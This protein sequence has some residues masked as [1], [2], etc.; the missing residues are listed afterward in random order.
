MDDRYER[1][2]TVRAVGTLDVL[3][4]GRREEA[5]TRAVRN[6]VR[7]AELTSALQV[8][9]PFGAPFQLPM[10]LDELIAGRSLLGS[11]PGTPLVAVGTLEWQQRDDPRYASR[12]RERG[13][14]VTEVVFRPHHIEPA[15]DT[16]EPGCDVWLEGRVRRE[17]RRYLHPER[18][19]PIAVVGLEIVVERMRRGSLAR[20]LEAVE[21]QVAIPVAHPDLPKLLRR[22]NLV[23]VDGMLE[24]VV[25]PLRTDDEQVRR[26]VAELDQRWESDHD[27]NAT[28]RQDEQRYARQ[29]ASLQ[30]TLLTRV[31]AGYV[32]VLE[33]E[34]GSL[35]EAERLR[36]DRR[37]AR[38]RERALRG[39]EGGRSS[40]PSSDVYENTAESVAQVAETAEG[41]SDETLESTVLAS[42]RP[43]RRVQPETD[44]Q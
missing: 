23:R 14:R 12:P 35:E 41:D 21:V 25:V 44:A 30:Q 24:R 11:E 7:G 6:A 32:A 15:E 22:G 20:M 28:S 9:G 2:N 31:V 39:G 36:E 29:R 13:R 16:D 5:T 18:R 27:G 1:V 34:P 4:V 3:R 8:R 19:V 37:S 17:A 42:T 10:R 43:R 33:G 26:A 38:E 40:A